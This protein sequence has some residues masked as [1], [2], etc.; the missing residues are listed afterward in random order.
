MFVSY[1]SKGRP[2]DLTF[3]YEVIGADPIYGFARTCDSTRT[4]RV[5]DEQVILKNNLPSRSLKGVFFRV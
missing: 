3:N 2:A 4:L 5:F 1:W